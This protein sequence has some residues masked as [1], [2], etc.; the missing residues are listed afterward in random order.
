MSI[1]VACPSCGRPYN[2]KDDAAGKRFKCKDCEAIVEVPA[3]GG[4]DD[5]ADDDYGEAYDPFEGAASGGGMP[6]P[7]RRRSSAGASGATSAAAI[8][9]LK[10]PA[11]FMY[12]VCGLSIGYWLLSLVALAAGLQGLMPQMPDPQQQAQSLK[13]LGYVIYV[14]H[15]LKDAFL[16]YAFSQVHA[17]RS[18]GVAFAGAIISVIPCI[19]SPC[20]ALG[21]PFGIWALVV[22]NDPTVKAAFR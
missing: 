12:V 5:F 6:A 7:A 20:C 11:I 13:A 1:S 8:E 18:Y 21:I 4:E 2:V 17:G 15:I 16:I 10:L 9:R 3:G 19:G 14:L 22:L